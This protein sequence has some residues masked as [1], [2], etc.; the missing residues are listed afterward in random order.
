MRV[1]RQAANQSLQASQ[2]AN[3]TLNWDLQSGQ[4]SVIATR[5]KL[6]SKYAAL[7]EVVIWECE[8]QIKLQ[9]LTDEKKAKE[10]LLEST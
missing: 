4:A 8:A 9:T 10:Q 5:E 6:S 3:A 2:E 1:T 7:N